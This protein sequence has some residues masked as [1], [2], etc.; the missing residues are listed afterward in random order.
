MLLFIALTVITVSPDLTATHPL[1]IY[2]KKGFIC[3][4]KIPQ[5][6]VIS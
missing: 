6:L 4:R 2:A 5:M 3:K 1:M